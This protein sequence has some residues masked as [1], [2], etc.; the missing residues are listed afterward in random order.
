MD[1]NHH[2]TTMKKKPVDNKDRKGRKKK[3]EPLMASKKKGED[4]IT[5]HGG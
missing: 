3:L 4:G 2:P 5:A 1:L